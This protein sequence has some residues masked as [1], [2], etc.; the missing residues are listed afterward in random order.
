MEVHTALDAF[1][2]FLLV[3]QLRTAGLTPAEGVAAM[4]DFYRDV[5]ADGCDLAGDGD[6]LLFQWGT[7]CWGDGDEGFELDITRQFIVKGGPSD[8]VW[9]LSLTFSFAPPAELRA[10]GAGS[11]WC[12]TVIT[13]EDFSVLVGQSSPYTAASARVDGMA[14]LDFERAG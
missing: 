4:L 10:L 5:R 7:Y 11:R 1:E 3:R 8:V 9:H 6:M 13:V 14:R 2:A 12:R